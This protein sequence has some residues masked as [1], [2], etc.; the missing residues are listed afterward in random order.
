MRCK[1]PAKTSIEEAAGII[2]AGGLVAMP[3]ETVYG[4]AGDAT[5]DAAIARIF[6]TKNR[7]QINPLIVHVA[8]IE[9][10]HQFGVFTPMA[11]RLA[12]VFWPGPLTLVVPRKE[13][14]PLSLLLSAGLDTVALRA[15]SHPAAQALLRAVNKPIAAPSA[16]LSGTIS[17]TQSAHV[18]AGLGDKID[19]I[20][21][22]GACTI[23]VE[24]TIVMIENDQPV[25]LR[26]GGIETN[27]IEEVTGVSL[28]KI[29]TDDR[30]LS[31][32]MLRSH[33]APNALMRLDAAAPEPGEAWLGFGQEHRDIPNSLNLSPQGSL[34]EAAA[35]LFAYLRQLDEQCDARNLRRIA[36]APIPMDGLGEAIN[37][38]LSRAAAP[39]NMDE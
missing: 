36:V 21:D 32:G 25:L 19:M 9:M 14:V 23:G 28:G 1:P 33:Y 13:E 16:N 3:T 39:R 17:P 26:A 10:A 2:R 37:D 31:P 27:A 8:D 35:N 5:N 11:T 4:L 12:D 29:S 38:R 30:V 20:L 6:E 34:R 18:V 7:P 22:G 24:S 15:P